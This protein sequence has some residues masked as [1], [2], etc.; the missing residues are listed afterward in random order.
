MRACAG[1]QVR[2]CSAALELDGSNETAL[3]RR[4]KALSQMHEYAVRAAQQPYPIPSTPGLQPLHLA[5]PCACRTDTVARLLSSRPAGRSRACWGRQRRACP[6]GARGIQWRQ[7]ALQA[8]RTHLRPA[9]S[10]GRRR[11]ATWRLSRRWAPP[12]RARPRR[13]CGSW[14]RRRPGARRRSARRSRACF[15]GR[16]SWN[17]IDSNRRSLYQPARSRADFTSPWSWDDVNNKR[18]SLDQPGQPPHAQ[19]QHRLRTRCKAGHAA[20]SQSAHGGAARRV[21]AA[22]HVCRGPRHRCRRRGAA[23][24][25]PC[26]AARPCAPSPPPCAHAAPPCPPRAPPARRRAPPARPRAPPAHRAARAPC[27]PCGVR[28]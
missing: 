2:L 8:L 12:R 19:V 1:A 22:G 6:V 23:C 16:R 13:R 24:C 20:R 3:R 25:A 7:Q 5:L 10:G 28:P 11:G 27:A 21:T 14:A 26:R 4:G 18:S 15:T 9:R 17:H